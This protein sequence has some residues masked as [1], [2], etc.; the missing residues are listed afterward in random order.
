LVFLFKEG[1]SMSSL[2]NN[3][4]L[5]RRKTGI[6]LKLVMY[7]KHLLG[8]FS[9]GFVLLVVLLSSLGL[10]SLNNKT[11]ASSD[12]I[13]RLTSE[14]IINFQS[15]IVIKPDGSLKVTETI[16]VNALGNKIKRGI[17]RD[18]PTTYKGLFDVESKVGFQLQQVLRNGQPETYKIQNVVNGQR[19]Y[20]GAE[21]V[22]IDPGQ[23]EYTIVYTTDRQLTFLGDHDELFFNITGNGWS[24]PIDSAEAT[25]DLS[26]LPVRDIAKVKQQLKLGGYTGA[27]GATDK[28]FSVQ[29]LDSNQTE[30]QQLTAKFTL[31]KPLEAGEGLSVFVE[32][33]KGY[34][35][36]ANSAQKLL[37]FIFDNFLVLV[38]MLFL[39]ML[40]IAGLLLW[41]VFGRDPQGKT[42]IPL[43][44]APDDITPAAARTLEQLGTDDKL[45]TVSLTNLAVKGY[46]QI[47]EKNGEFTITQ[48][49][50]SAAESDL[51]PEEEVLL[52]KFFGVGKTEFVFKQK[53]YLAAQAAR[54]SFFSS[55]QTNHTSKFVVKNQ[56]YFYLGLLALL[57]YSGLILLIGILAA[58]ED[59][60]GVGIWQA[61]VTIFT[62]IYLG[63]KLPKD[64]S[65]IFG[66]GTEFPTRIRQIV[67]TG[68]IF[69]IGLII[70]VVTLF[71]S[72]TYFPILAIIFIGLAIIVLT[73]FRRA[74]I[75]RTQLGRDKYDAVLGL[76]MYMLASEAE[77]IKLLGKEVPLTKEEYEQLLP[78]AIAL[79][80]DAA[81]TERFL[82]SMEKLTNNS[83]EI[84]YQPNW[85]L[86]AHAFTTLN[87]FS[88]SFAGFSQS[89]SSAI[90][91]AATSPSSSSSGGGGGSSGG[92]G[93]GGGGGGW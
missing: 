16:K 86:S 56:G 85:Y 58:G 77:R 38:G 7:I 54:T 80:I 13:V 74:I 28:N 55:I 67:I 90:S 11:Y 47:S 72:R 34:I 46:I 18:F 32:W 33:P 29:I 84:D 36:E 57:A 50:K 35:A 1:K 10:T 23:H 43:F 4:A 15:N 8:K 25:I 22:L 37:W 60:L 40:S 88:S 9:F 52:A 20:I 44:S 70:N 61:V 27:S 41:L 42:V 68:I 59:A 78:Y 6:V 79:D 3:Y 53:N 63:I 92:G 83:G 89:F 73:A 30:A 64:L 91:S 66:G 69:S 49:P 62:G 76:K 87:S 31:T 24:F 82:E 75:R 26:F 65:N 51:G 93:G 12:R 71:L 21:D 5:A 45:L 17:Y 39:I 2:K 81:W 19:V 48:L 14:R